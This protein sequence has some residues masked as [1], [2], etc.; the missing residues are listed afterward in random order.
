MKKNLLAVSMMMACTA[1]KAVSLGATAGDSSLFY[2]GGLGLGLGNDYSFVEVA[3]MI[4]VHL[5]PKVSTGVSVMY[6]H[7]TD[8]RG[9]VDYNADDY[10]ATLF[11]RYRLTRSFF[12]EADLEHLNYE[13]FFTDGSSQ[14]TSFNS[15]LAGAGFSTPLSRSVSF[16]L[17]ALYNFNYDDDD[18]P[19]S[20][21]VSIR[22]GFGI[23]F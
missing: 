17:T 3:P 11:G 9:A 7:A 2:G 16:T 18:S 15:V 12:L 1:A 5:T 10:G 8:K 21:P 20:D 23:G 22:A 13:R 14:R 4:G 6:R 19:Y